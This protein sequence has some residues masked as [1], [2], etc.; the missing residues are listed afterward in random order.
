TATKIRK[1]TNGASH[2][3]PSHATTA[4]TARPKNGRAQASQRWRRVVVSRSRPRSSS[5]GI[6]VRG[7]RIGGLL[8]DR[9][10]STDARTAGTA[11]DLLGDQAAPQDAGDGA[12]PGPGRVAGQ[13]EAGQTAGVRHGPLIAVAQR[14]ADPAARPARTACEAFVAARRSD[15]TDDRPPAQVWIHPPREP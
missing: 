1:T 12:Q 11:K 8:S 14:R 7:E 4:K 9:S 5:R 13:P 6:S 10:G 3:H 15:L 2:H